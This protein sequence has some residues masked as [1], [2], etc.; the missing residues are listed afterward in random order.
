MHDLLEGTVE[1]AVAAETT[2]KGQLLNGQGLVRGGTLLAETDEVADTQVVDI[3]VVSDALQ[4][5]VLAQIRAVDANQRGQLRE[6]EVVLQIE[7]RLLAMLPEQRPDVIANGQ[8]GVSLFLLFRSDHR[9][10]RIAIVDGCSVCDDDI[11]R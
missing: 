7:L 11:L 10:H 6:G 2:I 4:G 5:E 3:G 1:R 8:R 9:I